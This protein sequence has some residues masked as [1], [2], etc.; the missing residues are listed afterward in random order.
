MEGDTPLERSL[1]RG[2]RCRPQIHTQAEIPSHPE[3]IASHNLENESPTPSQGPWDPEC[4]ALGKLWAKAALP[5]PRG[6]TG[7]G[8]QAAGALTKH[9]E[10]GLGSRSTD[11]TLPMGGSRVHVTRPPGSCTWGTKI[12]V[13]CT[14]RSIQAPWT[15]ETKYCG[16]T[17][18]STNIHTHVPHKQLVH[19]LLSH[20]RAQGTHSA[21][22]H[23][24]GYTHMHET[25]AQTD[26]R[27]LLTP[28]YKHG[29]TATHIHRRMSDS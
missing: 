25:E 20:A 10:V 18:Q 13:T 23:L 14:E 16:Y 5:A 12:S 9:R 27:A 24:S 6:Q 19:T 22:V 28:I 7:P 1:A 4:P 15:L 26:T 2:H 29:H 8:A 17:Y 21:N 11:C 3:L